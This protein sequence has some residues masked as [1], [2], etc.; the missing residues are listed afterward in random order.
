MIQF[1]KSLVPK[2]L[3]KYLKKEVLKQGIVN[4]PKQVSSLI[5]D[6][7]T[8]DA[9]I[10]YN[11]YGGYCTPYSAQKESV[12]QAILKGEVYEPETIQYIIDNCKDGDVVQAGAFFGDFLPGIAKNISKNAKVWSFEPGSEFYRCAEITKLI[13]NLQ[14]VELFQVGLGAEKAELQLQV[15][16][17]DGR[18]LGGASR[19]IDSENGKFVPIV[20]EALDSMIPEDRNI[21]IIQFDLEGFEIPALKGA[22]KTIKRCKPIL[23]LEILSHN[24]ILTD[25]WFT[26]NILSLGYEIT[27]KVHNNTI[28][29]IPHN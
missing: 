2:K 27:G 20:I 28:I 15:A 19:I 10:A 25:D 17:A 4:A 6:E 21:S 23:I 22:I 3:K 14:N 7:F 8:L 29:T 11:K 18:Q 26:E 12:V 1:I 13:N 24:D 9:T 16:T 5:K